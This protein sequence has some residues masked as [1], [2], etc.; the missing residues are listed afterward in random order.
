MTIAPESNHARRI[1]GIAAL[2]TCALV[3][4]PTRVLP[5][6]TSLSAITQQ[7]ALHAVVVPLLA[8]FGL[9]LVLPKTLVLAICTLMLSMAHTELG[10]TDL[11]AGYLYPLVAVIGGV[12]IAYD[13]FF[14]PSSKP[15]PSE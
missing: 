15:N 6:A 2:L 11:F 10:S 1:M 5:D 4:D 7:I 14:K 8:A 9:W 12:V 13:L 3:F